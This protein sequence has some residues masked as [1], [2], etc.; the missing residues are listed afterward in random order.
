MFST[1]EMPDVPGLQDEKEPAGKAVLLY[2][3]CLKQAFCP[4]GR[5]V[6]RQ[7][8]G[9][10]PAVARTWRDELGASSCPLADGHRPKQ[11][12]APFTNDSSLLFVQF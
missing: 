6:S 4:Q 8:I 9:P 10:T 2:R 12:G 1:K 7:W 5:I 11:K 3:P